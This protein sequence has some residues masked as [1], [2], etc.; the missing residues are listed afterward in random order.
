MP[1]GAE[2]I[3]TS[4]QKLPKKETDSAISGEFSAADVYK[5]LVSSIINLKGKSKS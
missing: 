1:K 2:E 3:D 4:V 5:N